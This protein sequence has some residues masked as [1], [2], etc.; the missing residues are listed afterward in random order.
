MR[1][2]TAALAAVILAATPLPGQTPNVLSEAERQAGW[3]LLFDGRTTQGWRGYGRTDM[4]AGWTVVDGALTRTAP[5]GD[6][7]TVGQ[8]D[9]FELVVEW[10]VAK[11][12]NSGIFY[13]GV[14][15]PEPRLHPIYQTA[16]E[17]QVLDDA[18]HPDGRSP[19]TSAGSNYG[20]YPAPRG[21]VR[22]A[23]E[24]N[25]ARI[26]ARGDSVEHWLN[27][28]QVVAYRLGSHEWAARI[29]TSKFNEWP[30]Y[31]R[32]RSGHIGLQDHGDRVAFRS[33]KLR[34]F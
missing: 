8:Y 15:H 18:E 23:G 21:V 24:W 20:L 27:G 14:E 9:N 4:P 10:K 33:I 29:R 1:T 30:D 6:I 22:P 32:A 3:T 11:G 16:P 25:Q 34:R 19:L 17:M 5:A 28:V 13:R 12:G 2:A 26:V 31:G 7:V